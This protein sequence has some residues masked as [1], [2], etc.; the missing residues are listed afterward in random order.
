M[1]FFWFVLGIAVVAA[2][3][4]AGLLVSG[5]R[6]R[7]NRPK[8]GYRS[9]GDARL[10]I[11]GLLTIVPIVLVF[12]LVGVAIDRHYSESRCEQKSDVTG[13]RYV[14]MDYHFFGYECLLRTP[15]GNITETPVLPLEDVTQRGAG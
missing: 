15:S 11:G 10:F 8:N 5:Y 1:G 7:R 3:G 9:D 13:A 2:A 12:V 4:A 14:W 6:A